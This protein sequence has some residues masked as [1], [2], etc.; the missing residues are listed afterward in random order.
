[1]HT[2]GSLKT[3]VLSWAAPGTPLALPVCVYSTEEQEM[4]QWL[5]NRFTAPEKPAVAMA[6][7]SETRPT[8]S[9]IH[10]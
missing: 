5:R 7:V 1:M 10:I 2:G 4:L 9:L 6:P 3:C 8:L